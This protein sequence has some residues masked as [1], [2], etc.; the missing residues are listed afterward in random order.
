MDL[1]CEYLSRKEPTINYS[2]EELCY[3]T[4]LP[5]ILLETD[6]ALRAK[7]KEGMGQWWQNIQR[8]L[9]PL[10]TYIYKL[11]D[12]ELDYDME[13]C[14]WTLRR[15]PL[16]L[17]KFAPNNAH[18]DDLAF[19]DSIDRHGYHQMVTLLA[20]DERRVMKWNGNP[21]GL[22]DWGN[23]LEEEPGTIFTFPYWLGRYYGFLKGE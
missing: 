15:L 21:F 7:Y 23:P 16:D 3:L 4:Y 6:P 11:I 13:G 17:R 1:C 14:L 8:E 18:R 2:D 10:W 19:D 22:G 12:P 9:N 5:L 20:P